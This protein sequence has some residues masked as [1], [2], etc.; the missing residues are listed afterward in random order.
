MRRKFIAGL[1]PLLFLFVILALVPLACDIAKP[2]KKFRLAVPTTEYFYNYIAGHLKPFLERQGYEI[3]I[4]PAADVIDANRMVAEGEADLTMVNNH[5]TT[6]A[7]VLGKESDQL[8]AIMPL[9]TR[10]LFV[11][12][13]EKMRDSATVLEVFKDKRVGIEFLGGETHLTLNRFMG[14]SRIDGVKFEAYSDSADVNV[15]WG[16]YY[17]DRSAEWDAKGWHPFRF[18][19]NFIE[20]VMLHDQ[21]IR[22]IKLPALPGNPN[23]V[24]INTLATE[25]ILVANKSL[26][27]NA[28]YLLALA[29]F[30]NKVE[31]LRRDMMFSS[32][33]ENFDKERLLYPVHQGTFS[34]LVRDQPTF[35]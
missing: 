11:Y 3:S 29:I 9:T 13:K 28:C 32:I 6:V 2:Q 18:R 24:I 25:V 14:V 35:F 23:S 12:T 4:V 7:L 17:G 27:E 26:G 34:Y 8:R 10:L 1:V 30:Q 19:S 31:L 5:S 15:F 33:K 22:P 20:F 21:A 16:S